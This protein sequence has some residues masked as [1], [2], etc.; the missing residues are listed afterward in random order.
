MQPDVIAVE[1]DPIR[2]RSLQQGEREYQ[3]RNPF[4]SLIQ[5]I[6]DSLSKRTGVTPGSELLTAVDT[7]YEHNIPVALI[8]QDIR[9]TIRELRGIPFSEK[10]KLAGY[11]FFGFIS[12]LMAEFDLDTVPEQELVHEML[13]R[14]KVSFPNLYNALI[15]ERNELMAARLQKLEDEFDNVLAFVGAGHVEGIQKLLHR[16]TY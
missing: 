10:F 7:A 13:V 14:I 2:L 4:I 6:Q 12:P 15:D 3:L 11:L 9:I 16:N 8:D 1:L 5:Y